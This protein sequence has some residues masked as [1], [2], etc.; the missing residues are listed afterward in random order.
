MPVTIT[1]EVLSAAHLSEPELKREVALTL[2]A[3]ERLTFAQAS[4]LADMAILGFQALLASA[5]SQSTMEWTN[6]APTCA[7][8]AP[9]D[10]FD[11]RLRQQVRTQ[12]RRRGQRS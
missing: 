6:S 7:P 11:G 10:G 8:C 4:R 1:D 9:W 3:S 2:F 12:T 5:R